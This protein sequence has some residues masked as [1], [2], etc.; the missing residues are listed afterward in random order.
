[1]TSSSSPRVLAEL[2]GEPFSRLLRRAAPGAPC[3]LVGGVVRDRLL[4]RSG[5][6]VDMVV[7]GHGSEVATRLSELLPARRVD[8][9]GGR[10]A[11][12]R[13][14][15]PAAVVD[16]WDRH[17]M[18]VADDLWRRDLTINAMALDLADGQLE[19]PCSGMRDLAERSLRV[20]TDL[21]FRDDPLRVLRLVRLA[22]QLTGFSVEPATLELARQAVQ[23]LHT[24]ATE[25]IRD[26]LQQMMTVASLDVA[27]PLL[28]D[29]GLL[30]ALWEA[31]RQAPSAAELTA[32]ALRRVERLAAEIGR[33]GHRI[34]G[35]DG[36]TVDLE[37]A[38]WLIFLGDPE[39][40]PEA[41]MAALRRARDRGLLTRRRASELIRLAGAPELPD[42][43]P[44]RRRFLHHCGRLWPTA[45]VV[46]G[47]WG[48]LQAWPTA[49]PEI[50][51][52]A[53]SVAETL[54]APPRLLS[55]TEICRRLDL[56]PGPAIGRIQR[57]ILELQVAGELS[58]TADAEAWLALRRP[59]EFDS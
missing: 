29:I 34:G 42:D 58:S 57:R 44:G 16:L 47:A 21:S 22:A 37:A 32:E 20:T 59:Q 40:H 51:A 33:I 25:R 11:A 24:V 43:L 19:D 2:A 52:L 3:H 54:F 18:S 27:F 9:G 39:A 17:P 31:D 45:V 10:F 26:E 23:G 1:M 53:A 7:S 41:V 13:L 6:D 50:T 4:E 5:R 35:L 46:Q 48:R 8:L 49:V 36:Q 14:V 28:A 30:T 55:G 12:F 15:S 56:E 38:R